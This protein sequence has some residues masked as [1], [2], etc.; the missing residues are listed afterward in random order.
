MRT[1]ELL[2]YGITSVMVYRPYYGGRFPAELGEIT[3]QIFLIPATPGMG[4]E[5]RRDVL[6]EY[7]SSRR[8]DDVR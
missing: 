3:K 2:G 7:S 6:Y 1:R 4:L 5:W 8:Y